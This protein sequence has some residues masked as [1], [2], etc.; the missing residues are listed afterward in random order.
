VL[1]TKIVSITSKQVYWWIIFAAFYSKGSGGKFVVAIGGSNEL[2][3]VWQGWRVVFV[4]AT[5]HAHDGHVL[6]K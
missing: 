3:G 5:K 4:G 2:Y 6:H 1:N